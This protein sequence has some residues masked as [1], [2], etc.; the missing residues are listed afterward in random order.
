MD[1]KVATKLE[2]QIHQECHCL[3]WNFVV[4]LA[5]I[6]Y[7]QCTHILSKT[8]Y[9]GVQCWIQRFYVF[10]GMFLFKIDRYCSADQLNFILQCS[11]NIRERKLTLKLPTM[12]FKLRSYV[13]FLN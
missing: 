7:K 11:H 2:A 13:Y 9:C 4:H 1:L 3:H 10:C 5:H 12:L 8:D 6:Q